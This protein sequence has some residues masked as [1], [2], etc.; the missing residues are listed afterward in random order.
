MRSFK[1]RDGKVLVDGVVYG[2]TPTDSDIKGKV[3]RIQSI[4][5][6]GKG[7]FFPYHGTFNDG[8]IPAV[9]DNTGIV[10]ETPKKKGKAP[11]TELV[12]K[13]SKG[14]GIDG[15][16]IKKTPKTK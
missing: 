16:P 3:G 4:H 9:T 5:I 15:K 13:S 7:S 12:E 14:V 10:D 8:T 11:K 1:V 2:L 6:G